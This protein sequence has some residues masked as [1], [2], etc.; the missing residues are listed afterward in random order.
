MIVFSLSSRIERI[1]NLKIIIPRI[2]NQCDLLYLNL[3]G[4]PKIQ[5]FMIDDKIKINQFENAGSEIRFFNYNDIPNDSYY[6]TIDDDIDYP[7]DYTKV[8]LEFMELYENKAVCCVH[9]S[10]IEKEMEFDFYK[11]RRKVFH[12]KEGLEENTEV[13]IPGVG[14]SCFYKGYVKLNISDYETKNMSDVYT[15]CFLARQEIKRIS[16]KRPIEWLKPLDEFGVKIYGNNPYS[17]IDR[18]IQKYKTLL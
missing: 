3:V 9:G 5:D 11:R 1:E 6:F 18:M 14:T 12:F 2:L 8:M 13:M 7:Q 15:A 17:E 10:N 16:I 4:Y